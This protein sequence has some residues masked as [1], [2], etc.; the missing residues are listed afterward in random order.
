MHRNNIIWSLAK[1][2]RS[3]KTRVYNVIYIHIIY[4]LLMSSLLL[5]ISIFCGLIIHRVNHKRDNNKTSQRD[6]LLYI[7]SLDS[8]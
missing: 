7:R 8:H 5:C 1:G 6:I 4:V 3:V 2:F